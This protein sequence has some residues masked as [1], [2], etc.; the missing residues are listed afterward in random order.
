M[1]RLVT[2]RADALPALAEVFREYGYA[3]A[4]LSL[5]SERTGLGKGSL[6]HFFPGGKEE[7]ANA[8]LTEIDVWFESNIFSPLTNEADPER[9]IRHMFRA[10]DEYFQ[11]GER[12]CIV[13]A[14][15]LNNV[16]DCF[17]DR[18]RSYFSA[19]VATLSGALRRAGVKFSIAEAL[20]EE[21]VAGI[22]GALVLA[23]ALNEPGLFKRALTRICKRLIDAMADRAS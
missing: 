19:W 2:E 6:Y 16:R 4:S 9:G 5:I 18:I 23:R 11:S 13:G 8:V 14:F 3:G 21:T 22:Q 7:M 1:P 15:A 17:A 20:A 12:I 10:V